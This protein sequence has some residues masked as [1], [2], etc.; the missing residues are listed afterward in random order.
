MVSTSEREFKHTH[1][2]YLHEVMNFP[3][4]MFEKA[5]QCGLTRLAMNRHIRSPES[6]RCNNLLLTMC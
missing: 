3:V 5:K 2:S 4:V 1:L 6:I